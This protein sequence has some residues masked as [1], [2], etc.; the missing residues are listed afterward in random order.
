VNE[1][2]LA[3]F[4]SEGRELTLQAGQDLTV[5]TR[6]PDDRAALDRCFRAIHT[7]KGSAGLFDLPP[8]SRLLHAAEDL[9]GAIRVGALAGGGVFP[10]LVDTI[11][12]VDRWLD[13]LTRAGVLATGAEATERGLTTRLNAVLGRQLETE[14]A[15]RSINA[16]ISEGGGV[17]IRYTPRP[18]CYFSGD[19]PIAIIAAV[20]GITALAIAPREPFGD[21]SGYD[22]FACNLVIKAVSSAARP[23]IE[24]ALR[25]VVDQVELSDPKAP[26]DGDEV[27]TSRTIRVEAARVDRLADLTDELVI[28][29][30]GLAGLAG[31]ADGLADGHALAQALRAQQARIDRLV[32]DLHGTVSRIRLTPL[33]PLFGRFPRLAREI[34]RSLG[35]AVTLDIEGGDIEVDKA[36]VDGLHEPLLHVLRNAL[37]HGVEAPEA[38]RAAGKSAE[39]LVR[40]SS[41]TLGEQVVIEIVDDGA[42]M[43]PDRIRDLAVARGLISQ[44]DAD[45]EA[46]DARAALDLIFLPGFSTAA[47]VSDLSGRGVGM[48]AVRS[49]IARLGGRVEIAS[50]KGQGSTVRFMLP[51]SM[52]LTKVMVVACGEERYGLALDGVVETARVT[53]DR[54]TAVR[55]GEAFILRDQVVPLVRLGDLVGAPKVKES[56][57]LRVIV[58]R[59]GEELVGFAVDAIVDRLDAA[60]RPMAGLLAGARGVVGS[61]LLADGAVLMVLDLQELV[62]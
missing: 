18:D 40:L 24:A 39:S 46:L 52:V 59:V 56:S 20:P 33:A 27:S 45:A 38:R 23:A 15:P 13:E 61:T 58:A 14:P 10:V 34:A 54:I 5:L 6:R 9:M 57:A 21:L 8:M 26:A 11:D 30:G 60:V 22:P 29:K 35:K 36:V 55:A 3:E 19:D 12:Q 42:G 49:A 51:I 31:R 48:D 44:A 25:L 37:D 7:L 28:A 53:P 41:R 2:L 4:L 32:A 16:P 43:D 50:T 17:T 62:G 1:D 47:T